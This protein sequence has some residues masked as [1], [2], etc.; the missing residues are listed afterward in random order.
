MNK[1]SLSQ[2]F[3]FLRDKGSVSSRDIGRWLKSIGSLDGIKSRYGNILRWLQ[4]IETGGKISIEDLSS[5][6]NKNME[7]FVR[8]KEGGGYK[9]QSLV[10]LKEICRARGLKVSGNKSE[11][12]SRIISDDS[13][14][15]DVASEDSAKDAV[16]M[17]SES[18][19]FS[20][21]KTKLHEFIN[22]SGGV[23]YSRN[24][25]RY[26][27]KCPSA[28]GVS[29]LNVLKHHYFSL[30]KFLNTRGKDAE[31][32]WDEDYDFEGAISKGYSEP[33]EGFRVFIE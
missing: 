17:M 18:E 5:A 12:I 25:G 19:A 20:E 28:E 23:A 21:I 8:L 31:L 16:G 15:P 27:S 4:L 22:A 10:E 11:I 13:N 30:R 14:V 2:L 6:E 32:G 3:E 33:V 26:L 29:T 7:Y 24:I 9:E 1:T